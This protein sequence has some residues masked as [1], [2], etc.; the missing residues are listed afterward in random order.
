MYSE[1]ME[2]LEEMN[3]WEHMVHVEEASC[4]FADSRIGIAN[5][6]LNYILH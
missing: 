2:L 5:S 1:Y 3:V 6:N 4:E